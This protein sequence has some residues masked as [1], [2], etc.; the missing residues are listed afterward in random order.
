M[1]THLPACG[2]DEAIRR[3]VQPYRST[4]ISKALRYLS[5]SG[6]TYAAADP[7]SM[8]RLWLQFN[9]QA[10]ATPELA[11]RLDA[12]GRDLRE[13]GAQVSSEVGPLPEQREA[14]RAAHMSERLNEAAGLAQ[15][16]AKGAVDYP[17][18]TEEHP[19]LA[20]TTPP[21]P[22]TP[23]PLKRHERDIY[24]VL[25]RRPGIEGAIFVDEITKDSGWS[26][27]TV[28]KALKPSRNLRKHYGVR[29]LRRAGYYVDP[30]VAERLS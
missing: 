14:D 7:Q 28:K 13:C 23:P 19:N 22:D 1:T 18:Q 25:S 2:T 4:L 24:E 11:E 17:L 27:H 6:T 5:E 10:N 21:D 8:L 29:N 30:D 20:E 26:K 15:D 12:I 16:E 3:A 9:D